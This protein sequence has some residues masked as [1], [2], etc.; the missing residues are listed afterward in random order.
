MGRFRQ[1]LCKG[2]ITKATHPQSPPA[3]WVILQEGGSR[4]V[5]TDTSTDLISVPLYGVCTGNLCHGGSASGA[6]AFGKQQTCVRVEEGGAD[7]HKDRAKSICKEKANVKQFLQLE[8]SKNWS[9]FLV[10]QFCGKLFLPYC[11]LY[12]REEMTPRLICWRVFCKIYWNFLHSS[13]VW[14]TSPAKVNWGDSPELEF[15]TWPCTWDALKAHPP[16]VTSLYFSE[17]CI[18]IISTLVWFTRW[19]PVFSGSVLLV[20]SQSWFKL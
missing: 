5:L 4:V 2:S 3:L 19:N 6:A 8:T 12:F 9:W 20:A 16:C 1:G 14:N 11:V 17:L 18:V 15:Y 7:L 10:S 13:P